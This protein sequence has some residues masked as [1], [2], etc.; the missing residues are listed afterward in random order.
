MADCVV[1]AVSHGSVPVLDD[2]RTKAQRLSTPT[3]LQAQPL[4]VRHRT[5]SSSHSLLSAVLAGNTTA[6]SRAG[7]A[8]SSARGAPSPPLSRH[9]LGDQAGTH[10]PAIPHSNVS[11]SRSPRSPACIM[12]DRKPSSHVQIMTQEM[13]YPGTV[14]SALVDPFQ[15]MR[16][17]SL[18]M[19]PST[20]LRD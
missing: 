4:I 12:R 15:H 8:A 2:G 6:R 16:L 3:S 14:P 18:E 20:P 17:L 5:P 19:G 11:T 13:I 9:C 7:H 1:D 10:T